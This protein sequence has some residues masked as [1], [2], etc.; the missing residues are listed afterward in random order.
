MVYCPSC[1]VENPASSR[2]C[3]QC[4]ARLIPVIAPV[5]VAPVAPVARPAQPAMPPPSPALVPAS[6]G[7]IIC[8]QCGSN[9][10]PGEAF[11]DNCGAP[12]SAPAPAAT[13]VANPIYATGLAP[14]PTYPTPQPTMPQ[15]VIVQ[16]IAPPVAAMPATSSYAPVRS[17]LAPARLV[18]DNGVVIALPNAAQAI[19][20]RAD[21][22]SNYAPEID[23]TDYGALGGGVGRRHARLLL[24]QGQIAIEDLDSTN[25]TLVNTVRLQPR[26]PRGLQDG[27]TLQLGGV[28]MQFHS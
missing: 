3:D 15:P 4:G 21:A 20:G 6:S 9:A 18:F 12:L 28:R 13:T 23:L 16:P 19:I 5:A 2:F 7:P 26:Q 11:C 22:V 17:S 25:G 8:P 24:Q 10:I 14:Q 1:G 27:D